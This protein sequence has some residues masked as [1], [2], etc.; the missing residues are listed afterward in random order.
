ME[1]LL[2][3]FNS[4]LPCWDAETII[5]SGEDPSGLEYLVKS[6]DLMKIASA[7]VLTPQGIKTRERVAQELFLPDTPAGEIIID[8]VRADEMLELNRMTQFLDRAFVTDWGI[9]EISVREK[10][11]IMPSL[12]DDEFF[13]FDGGK[14]KA[15]W[16][17]NERVRKFLNDFP[18]FG[19]VA[20]KFSA[21][22]QEGLD[23]WAAKNNFSYGNLTV[24]F[25]LRSRADFNH[26]KDYEQ[27][28]SDKYKFL[29]SDQLFVQKVPD[30]IENILPFI[31]KLHIFLTEQRRI[32]L[33]GWFDIDHDENEDWHLLCFVTDTE[34]QLENLTAVLQRWGHDLIDP[35]NPLFIIGSSIERL[36]NQKEQKRTIY[37]WF[38]E[39]TVRILRPD[40]PDGE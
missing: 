22:G 20:R 35:V 5:T 6:G 40:A 37:D 13:I 31:G 27:F 36:R 15:V 16:P 32:F 12:N 10:F 11:P 29:D 14:V 25:V 17:E 8:E 26:Y 21:A 9:K 19:V 1:N 23:A 39:E 2:L 18:N 28:E 33:P 34:R 30:K 3:L 7:Y 24:D 4:S 38:Q